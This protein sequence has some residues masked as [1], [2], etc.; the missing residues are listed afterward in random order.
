MEFR[1][2]FFDIDE[3]LQSF[4]FIIMKIIIRNVNLMFD[5]QKR[6]SS[7]LG[8]KCLSLKSLNLKKKTSAA[9]QN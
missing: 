2:L 1:I 7:E 9:D 4:T 6:G 5:F 3:I 8:S